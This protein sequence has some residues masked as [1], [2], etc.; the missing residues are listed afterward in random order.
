[1]DIIQL[2]VTSKCFLRCSNCTRLVAH[3]R[4]PKSMPVETFRRAVLSMYGWETRGKVLGIIGGEPTLHPDFEEIALLFLKLWGRSGECHHGLLPVDDFNRYANER[5]FDRTS[6][7]GLWTSLGESYYRH[8]EVI[9][10]VFDHQTINTHE[11]PGLHQT[12]LVNRA[13]YCRVNKITDDEWLANR[14]KCWVQNTWSASINRHGAYFCEVAAAIDD[15]FN[16]GK[17]AWPIENGWWKRQPG[18][19]NDQLHLCDRCALAQPGPAAVARDDQDVL[20]S[21]VL[22][23]LEDLRSPA[24]EKG[25]FVPFDERAAEQ[26]VITTK[27][28]YMPGPEYRVGP[29][30]KSIRPHKV[31]CVVACVGRGHHLGQVIRHNREQVDELIVVTDA[32]D[33]LTA[34][35]AGAAGTRVVI[36]QRWREDDAAFNKG[37]M[38]N[39]G[40]AAI[41]NPD[42]VLLTDADVK[43]P[44]TLADYL[45]THSLNPGVLYGV[46]RREPGQSPMEVTVNAQMN[47]FF[48][49]F[50]RRCLKLRDAWPAVLS[51]NFCSAGG[52]DSW[53]MQQFKRQE[54]LPLS[55]THL[56][57]GQFGSGWNGTLRRPSWRQIGML[58]AEGLIMLPDAPP[59]EDLLLTDTLTGCS[60]N[61]NAGRLNEFVQHN[62]KG[63]LI[64]NGVDIGYCHIHV[65]GWVE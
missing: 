14:D 16:D 7:R 61:I 64:F 59:C 62:D 46:H 43:L 19:F 4:D 5:L 40:L 44:A 20:G 41:K 33:W 34:D 39:D 55:V 8:Y 10:R 47:G 9:Q 11:N 50:N 24:V 28:N 21:S 51:E 31:S 37:K 49:L 23:Q 63:G 38:L 53:F 26:R 60:I 12:L 35:I 13:E 45:R 48:Q 27:D 65:A 32:D 2:D 6:G 17:S 52:I 54:M 57:H 58:T 18:D 30:N 22:V 1:M 36:S 15:L 42:W 56:P 25:K 3:F 29:D